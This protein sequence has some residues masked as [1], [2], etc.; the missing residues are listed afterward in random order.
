MFDSDFYCLISAGQ[1]RKRKGVGHFWKMQTDLK[2]KKKKKINL[3][4]L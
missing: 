3:E 4:E 1:G 2:V